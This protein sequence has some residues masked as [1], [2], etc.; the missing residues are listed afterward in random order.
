[1]RSLLLLV[2]A[3]TLSACGSSEPNSEAKAERD[4]TLSP[5]SIEWYAGD[6]AASFEQA[7]LENKPLFL[8][9]GA[10]WCPPCQEIKATVF[11]DPRFI[12]Q[13]QLVIPV[14]LDGDTDRAQVWGER[15]VVKGY[16]TMILFNAEGEELTRIPGGI[17]VGLYN[18][19]LALGLN[20]GESIGEL[21]A[22]AKEGNVE[23]QEYTRLA[24]Y[25]WGQDNLDIELESLPN[26]LRDFSAAAISA[27][28]NFAG[29]RLSMHYL[30]LVSQLDLSLSA[31]EKTQARERLTTVLNSEEESVANLDYLSFYVTE[32]LT[33][34]AETPAQR[35]DLQQ[36]WIQ[37]MENLRE[38]ESLSTAEQLATW[39]PAIHSYWLDNPS[40]ALPF[41]ETLLA[42][43]NKADSNTR[44]DER[45]SV[46]HRATR[47][48]EA[49]RMYDDARNLLTAEI[50]KSST[51]FY[52][53]SRLAE[54][55]EEL[56]NYS[57]AV[58]WLQ[59]A[60]Q[61]ATGSATGF[62]WGVEYLTGMMRMTPEATSDI[63]HAM[64]QVLA[65]VE[66][67]SELFSGRN[68]RRL[69]TLYRATKE[70]QANGEVMEELRSFVQENCEA[71]A[72]DRVAYKNCTALLKE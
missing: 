17:D 72:E 23:A 44:G 12:A 49:A 10:E 5:T 7:R 3:I 13:T 35:Q 26:L 29:L 6:V 36:R 21:I 47:V 66:S 43:I 45:Q 27:G 15:F 24:L 65:K 22:R 18:N 8:Y 32:L 56:E 19:A 51:P 9:W 39:Y 63:T 30:S 55:E 46:M 57:V 38:R 54:L 58:S 34:V 25:A 16:P 2:L 42:A 31:S 20:S 48:L 40:G 62:Q 60:Y 53:M 71:A 69:N 61:N 59:K 52:F 41:A 11:K 37:Q 67:D 68:F 70:W 50:P 33:L 4:N 64:P 1:M 14:Y 28:N